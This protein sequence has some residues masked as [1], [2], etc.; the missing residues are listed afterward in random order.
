MNREIILAKTAGFCK[1][2]K[3]AV[4][5]LNELVEN[6]TSVCTLGEIIHND[7]MVSDFKRRGVDVIN[8]VREANGRTVVIRAH[9]V[10]PH[11]YGKINANNVSFIDC[12]CVD[13]N[14]IHIKVKA[15]YD[16][17][18]KIIIAGDAAH[19]EVI[20]T[21]G[22][23]ENSAIII[24]T[25]DEI[26]AEMFQQDK[27]YA[28]FA[29]TTFDSG[30]FEK[31]TTK[32]LTLNPNCIISNTI[33]SATIVRQNEAEKL[34]K[35]VDTML[36]IGSEASANTRALYKICKKN[37]VN[38]FLIE[39]LESIDDFILK[40]LRSSV[41]IGITAGASTPPNIIKGVYDHMSEIDL[42]NDNGS[43]KSF[44]EMM[45]EQI[46]VVKNGEIVKGTVISV[47]NNE[48]LVNLG[49]K[50]DGIIERGQ[51]SDDPNVEVAELVKPGDEIEAF[52]VRVNDGDG[53]VVL[54]RKRHIEKQGIADVEAAFVNETVLKGRVIGPTKGGVNVSLNSVRAFVPASQLASR[55]VDDVKDY[56]GKEFDFNVIKFEKGKRGGVVAGR[57]ALA[58]KLEAELKAKL[59]ETLEVG[60]RVEGVVRRITD[61]GAFV[62]LGG[63]DGLIHITQLSFTRIKKV[64]EILQVG[65]NVTAVVVAIDKEKDRISLSYREINNNPWLNIEEK[66]PLHAIVNGKVVRFVDFGMFVELETGLD[67]LVHVSQVSYEKGKKAKD[68]Y[69]LGDVIEVRVMNINM[70]KRRVDL[71][72]KEVL[73]P[74]EWWLEEPTTAAEAVENLPVE[75]PTAE[76]VVT[77]ISEDVVNTDEVE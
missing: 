40:N 29:Q 28:L 36:I 33:C 26:N 69:E 5:R 55:P 22:V 9:G 58:T 61:F 38:T 44:E 37:L 68:L 11:V 10:P 62:D 21:N 15:A 39:N 2:V 51:F 71:S 3:M 41:K 27:Q 7:D 49:Y 64:E 24:Q 50:S 54:S 73:G 17:G 57:R 60:A 12:T 47:N 13:V 30:M 52:V 70:E 1:G 25:D 63:V 34:S 35:T 18:H 75:E 53:N 48:V 19:A 46:T 23:T 45:N 14:S 72:I 56:I 31:I 76:P 20:G 4:G 66:Y 65:D 43:E 6:G 8:E 42:T 74:P 16:Q 67:G 32:L 59:F 77:E